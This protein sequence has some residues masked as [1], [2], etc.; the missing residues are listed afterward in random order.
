[1][2]SWGDM[3]NFAYGHF[4]RPTG[5]VGRINKLLEMTED[6]LFQRSSN[7]NSIFANRLILGIG[8]RDTEKW[9]LPSRNLQF[10]WR[11]RQIVYTDINGKLG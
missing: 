5:H 6:Q 11:N 10:S 4:N 8:T 9:S 2:Q 7:I 1:M 3:F